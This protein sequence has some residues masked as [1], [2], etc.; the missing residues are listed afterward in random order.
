MVPYTLTNPTDSTSVTV[1]P[2][3]T[4]DWIKITNVGDEVI[5]ITVDANGTFGERTAEFTMSYPKAK[6]VVFTVTQA[7]RKY[8]YE[9]TMTSFSGGY[10][11]DVY[12]SGSHNFMITLGEKPLTEDGG[13]EDGATYCSL[14]IYSNQPESRTP[15]TLPAGEYTYAPM[16]T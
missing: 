2:T 14:D 3:E 4:Y 6:D 1:E 9:W 16:G 10:F 5:D 12:G 7:S 15:P 11:G 13:F 8:D